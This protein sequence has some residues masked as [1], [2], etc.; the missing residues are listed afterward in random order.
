MLNEKTILNFIILSKNEKNQFYIMGV[1]KTD[2]NNK[3]NSVFFV[4]GWGVNPS[5]LYSLGT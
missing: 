4:R 5:C 3:C 1:L 2:F